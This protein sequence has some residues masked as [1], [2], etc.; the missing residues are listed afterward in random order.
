MVQRQICVIGAI[1]SQRAGEAFSSDY[2]LPND[3]AYVESCASVG[4]MMFA[5]RMLEMELDGRY[6][7]L[8]ER[9]LYNTGLDSIAFDWRHY[10]YVNPLEVHPKTLRY[11]GI[12][13]HVSPVRRRWFGCACCP[14]NIARLCTSIGHYIYTA[15]TDALYV[16]LYGGNR[17]AISVDGH[18]LRLLS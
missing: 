6:A 13:N 12:Y 7:D 2:D 3:T 9:A 11:N 18:A 1:G 17:V 16:N 8:M 10:F 14:P 15:S 5:R 4:L